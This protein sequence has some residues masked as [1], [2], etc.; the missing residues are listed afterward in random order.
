MADYL[1]VA[2]RALA[3]LPRAPNTEEPR[4]PKPSFEGLAGA[5]LGSFQKTRAEPAP[6]GEGAVH[7][8][9]F[10]H[11]P[12]CASYHLYRKNNVGNYECLTCELRDIDEI[13][14]R[15]LQ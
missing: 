11:C 2:R 9:V 7:L 14:A 1:A 4:P 10:P 8:R 15:R 5:T 3:T 6:P 12:R 13:T